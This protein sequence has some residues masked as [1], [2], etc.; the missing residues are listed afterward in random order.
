[1]RKLTIT[2][3]IALC[4][5]L[6]VTGFARSWALDTPVFSTDSQE[7]F[8][9]IVFQRNEN[10]LESN[11]AGS[12]MVLAKYAPTNNS[13]LWKLVGNADNFQ[14]IGQNGEYATVTGTGNA[15]RLAAANQPYAAGFSMIATEN[16]SYPDAFEIKA[17]GLSGSNVYFNQWQGPNAGNPIGFWS[18]GDPNNPIKFL[19]QSEMPRENSVRTYK[20]YSVTG[21][22]NYEPDNNFTLWYSTPGTRSVA[23]GDNNNK[24]MQHAMPIGNG[25]FGAQILGG[26]AQDEISFNEKTLWSGSALGAK[27]GEANLNTTQYGTYHSFGNLMINDMPLDGASTKVT[28]YLRTLD[29]TRAVA[30]V[31]WQNSVGVNFSRR[32]IASNPDGVVAMLL[33][34]D[35]PGNIN[36]EFQV[37]PGMK[38]DVEVTYADGTGYFSGRFGDGTGM[39]YDG[40][41]SYF[42][43]FKVIPDGGTLDTGEDCITVSKANSVLVLLCG[44]TDYDPLTPTYTSDTDQLEGRI[45]ALIAA[46]QAKGWDAMLSDHIADYQQYYN[47][48]ELTLDGAGNTKPVNTL[49][50]SYKGGTAK[51]DQ[52]RYL[53]QLYFQYGRYLN[54]CSNR[55]VDLPANLQGIWGAHNV[56]RPYSGQVMPWNCDIHSNINVQMNFWP[57][58]PTNLSEMHMPFLNYIINQTTIQP[59]WHQRAVKVGQTKGWTLLTE[60]NIFGSGSDWGSNYV[61]ANAWYCTH[62][63]QHYLYTLDTDFLKR[64]LPAMWGACEFWI[65][66]LVKAADGTYE[67]PNEWSPE[68][69]PSQNATAHSQQLV[70]ELFSE[71]LAAIEVLGDDCGISSS[72]IATLRNRYD[73]LDRGLAIETYTGA[74]GDTKDGVKK[75]DPILREWK[76]SPYTVGEGGGNH[77]HLSHMMCLYPF[78]QVTPGSA[79][80]EAV[81]NSLKLRGNAA[82]GWSLG[83][84]LNAWA[85]A[86]DGEHAY[87]ILSNALSNNVYPNLYDAHPPF[88]IDGNFGATAAMAELLLQSHNGGLDLLPALPS[89]WGD[90]GSV[91]GLRAIGNFGVDL[92]WA[93]QKLSKAVV[94]SD[95][96]QPTVV[97][98]PGI[99]AAKVSDAS[100]N[101][102]SFKAESDDA[103]S[104]ETVKGG[105]YTFVMPSGITGV[106]EDVK[107]ATLSINGNTITVN[108]ADVEALTVTDMTGRTLA[109]ASGNTVTVNTT[110]KTVL[111]TATRSNGATET[112]KA[113]L[114]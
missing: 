74:Y 41:L 50:S 81:V 79:E 108:A 7:K 80:Y 57:C 107:P 52:R 16:S 65:E 103:I 98:Y 93:N 100:G 90:G 36:L 58:E 109:N 38:K 24:W 27:K 66:R 1:M 33:E 63:W 31:S 105:I 114:N 25:Q 72:D 67:C 21:I 18:A 88:Q 75:G 73:N 22:K 56:F 85:R 29:L 45:R 83:W 8:Y 70:A 82:T 87:L 78:S 69:G 11:G 59:Q 40:I 86:R 17:N 49:Q 104:F 71:T 6:M 60:N 47:R 15:A 89:A 10:V 4:L 34:A 55:G 20:E 19:T 96:G 97:R 91:T 51:A 54:I 77:R 9:Y 23:S 62:L 113:I 3:R 64:A 28:E 101:E 14:I 46:A 99:A 92:Y 111:V 39:Q 42:A 37:L 35:Q 106:Y 26:V 95:A 32:F 5:T 43:M 48:V 12:N 44:G 2:S 110:S 53:E 94:Y 112:L 68:H 102:V 13:Q 30:S 84:K 61:I 76:Y